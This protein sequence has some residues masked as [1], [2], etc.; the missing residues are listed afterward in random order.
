MGWSKA[1]RKKGI[2]AF[3]SSTARIRSA[4]MD[5]TDY[6]VHLTSLVT[7][8][9]DGRS[10]AN[11]YST[12]KG[13]LRDGFIRSSECWIDV[14]Q[15]RGQKSVRTVRGP[16][17][18]VCFTEQPLEQIPITVARH[19]KY[20]GSGIA[21][22]KSDLFNYGGRPVIYGDETQLYSLPDDWKFLWVRY[23]PD[24][25]RPP[26]MDYTFEREWRTRV[27]TTAL[28]WGGKLEGMPLVLP[29]DFTRLAER[30]PGLGR[31]Q[32]KKDEFPDL[33]IL[34][35]SD[36]D[37]KPMRDYVNSLVPKPTP[38]T[39]VRIYHEV[40]RKAQIV[41]LEHVERMN[42]KGAY[43]RIEDLPRPEEMLD[44]LPENPVKKTYHF[45]K[46]K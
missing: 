17:E 43:R 16:H 4:R 29:G 13:I 33:R 41:S 10:V 25:A 36:I 24:Q 32:T 15:G 12:L 20:R 34:V 38:S 7:V 8:R 1:Y 45:M 37:V 21:V 22:H 19:S 40:L 9:K 5:L 2:I 3:M 44:I 14:F 11:R 35:N 31:W 46:Q 18:V 28:P 42:E 39:Y 26:L 23:N 6:V 30:H 27:G